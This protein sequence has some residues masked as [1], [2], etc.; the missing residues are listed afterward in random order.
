MA[1]L[2]HDL[3]FSITVGGLELMNSRQ[4]ESERELARLGCAHLAG[5]EA[6]RVLVG[7]LG[8][9]FT[10][11][12]TLDLLGP[13][14]EVLV[15]E[16]SGA[17]VEWNRTHFPEING[18]ALDDPRVDLRPGDVVDLISRSAAAFDAILLDVDNGP[19]ALT[20]P[21]NSR[22][23]CHMGIRACRLALRDRGC[24]AVWS[25]EP[26]RRFEQILVDSDLHV[27][28]YRV[29]AHRGKKSPSRYVFV[30]SEDGSRLPPGGGAPR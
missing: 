30:A 4:N 27:R 14:A 26:S 15:G 5:I 21:D 28:R 10:L 25:V 11:R 18:R 17:V 16:L 1:L 7:G 12:E 3:D 22:L 29:D 20:S 13:G 19:G 23:Y 24:L 6:P 8:M 9:G 2:R